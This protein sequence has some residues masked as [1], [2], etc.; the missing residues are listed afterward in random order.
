MRVPSIKVPYRADDVDEDELRRHLL[1]RNQGEK[2]EDDFNKEMF[3]NRKI[4][5]IADFMDE[6]RDND[7][8]GNKHSKYLKELERRE[9][10]RNLNDKILKWKDR[11]IARDLV[12]IP[13]FYTYDFEKG[14]FDEDTIDLVP[15]GLFEIQR[16]SNGKDVSRPKFDRL[17]STLKK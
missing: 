9:N 14:R 15:E 5:I 4:N 10:Q 3:L 7:G 13:N 16:F 8:L 6:M 11:E 2:E 1:L 17:R 12:Q